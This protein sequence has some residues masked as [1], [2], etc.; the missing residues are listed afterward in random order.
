MLKVDGSY[1]LVRMTA[2]KATLGFATDLV[3]LWAASLTIDWTIWVLMMIFIVQNQWNDR[4]GSNLDDDLDMTLGEILR[5]KRGAEAVTH[6]I[7]EK[8]YSDDLHDQDMG[9]KRNDDDDSD[10]ENPDVEV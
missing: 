8:K 7:P 1:E 9:K 10:E 3:T 6:H 2:M 5:G 4:Y